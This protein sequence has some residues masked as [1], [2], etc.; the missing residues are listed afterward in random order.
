M[1]R[2]EDASARLSVLGCCARGTSVHICSKYRHKQSRKVVK[3]ISG[4]LQRSP[5][6]HFHLFWGFFSP[7]LHSCFSAWSNKN[8]KER[9]SRSAGVPNEWWSG[10]FPPVALQPGRKT[11]SS[12]KLTA[13]FWK[14]ECFF[15]LKEA[16]CYLSCANKII[17]YES[18]FF[19]GCTTAPLCSQGESCVS[20]SEYVSVA[21]IRSSF[22]PEPCFKCALVCV[23]VKH[24]FPTDW[25]FLGSRRPSDRRT[26]EV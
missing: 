7:Y 11:H 4:K 13:L 17:H 8:I 9:M 26:D 6:Y 21:F 16:R 19:P 18:F 15:F 14:P 3:Q 1:L 10:H 2:R 20:G 22:A 5:K 12:R 25:D 23:H 24:L